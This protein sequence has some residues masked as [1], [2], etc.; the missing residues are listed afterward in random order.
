MS[1]LCLMLCR[2]ATLVFEALSLCLTNVWGS[3]VLPHL[4]LR[5]CPYVSSV[6]EV[7][8][9]WH[10][11][12]WGSVL[13]SHLCL[14]FCRIATLVFEALFLCLTCVWGSVLLSHQCLRF[15]RIATLVFE[16]L[17]LCLTCVWGSAGSHLGARSACRC[18]TPG[19]PPA[20]RRS[21][22]TRGPYSCQ[23]DRHKPTVSTQTHTN[24]QMGPF[25]AVFVI[26]DGEKAKNA[27]PF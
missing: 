12:V 20:C 1:H 25:A 24:S 21:S 23:T 22:R 19:N 9:Y 7:P 2:I 8:P 4:C 14:R 6:F 11:C 26:C 5:L 15:C 13:M 16:S 17:F 18:G 3:A 10:T 27:S